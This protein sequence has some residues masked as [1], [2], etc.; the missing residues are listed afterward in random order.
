M[1]SCFSTIQIAYHCVLQQLREESEALDNP[2]DILTV[3][4]REGI[5]IL[6]VFSDID[7]RRLLPARTARWL[8]GQTVIIFILV[9]FQHQHQQL[10]PGLSISPRLE[11]VPG[12]PGRTD[13]QT[14]L[15]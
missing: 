11:S 13:G 14:L 10:K 12:R 5:F 7:C 2:D 3:L 15:L 6:S 4:F 1:C 9:C 8:D